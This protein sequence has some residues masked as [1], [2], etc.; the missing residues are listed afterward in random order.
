VLLLRPGRRRTAAREWAP[1]RGGRRWIGER[2]EQKVFVARRFRLGAEEEAG[3]FQARKATGSGGI[4][5]AGRLRNEPPVRRLAASAPASVMWAQR[6]GAQVRGRRPVFQRMA[7]A[8]VRGGR[9]RGG[10]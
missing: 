2:A 10:R 6:S 1:L 7:S 8:Q 3:A 9:R 5:R 4:A